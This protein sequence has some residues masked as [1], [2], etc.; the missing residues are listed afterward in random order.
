MI[1]KVLDCVH[2][3]SLRIRAGREI[4]HYRDSIPSTPTPHTK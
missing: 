3:N 1:P 4:Y 2:L